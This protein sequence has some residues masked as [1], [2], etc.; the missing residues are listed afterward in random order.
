MHIDMSPY[1][2]WYRGITQ[3]VAVNKP[4]GEKVVIV[5]CGVRYGCSARIIKDALDL[6]PPT[7][8]GYLQ[9]ELI[10]IDPYLTPTM[11]RFMAEMTADPRVKYRKEKCEILA[12]FFD[13]NSIDL[14][15]FDVSMH[16]QEGFPLDPPGFEHGAGQAR[17][18]FELYK[19]K[20]APGGCIVW[21][22]A[23]DEFGVN[24]IVKEIEKNMQDEWTV[25]RAVP[26]KACMIAAPAVCWKK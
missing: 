3:R 14:L 21:H 5:E 7:E 13:D 24:R 12:P 20:V 10:L 15:H 22:D 1:A 8:L 18:M 19:G 4:I 17:E 23:T 11:G 25:E 9:Y 16:G 2:N 6:V 26:Q